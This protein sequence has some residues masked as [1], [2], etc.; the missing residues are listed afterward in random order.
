[1]I[2]VNKLGLKLHPR[3]EYAKDAHERLMAAADAH[4]IKI[5][6]LTGEQEPATV[7][8]CRVVASIGGD[9]TL[10]S[11]VRSAYPSDTPVWGINVGELGFLTTSGVNEIEQ[12]VER[13]AKGDYQVEPRTMIEGTVSWGEHETLLVAL[14]DIVLHRQVPG[15]GLMALDVELN[16][17]FLAA[18]E[19][20][21]LIIST[22]TGSTGY[23]LSAGGSI[24]SPTVAAL[25][26]TPV[27]AH[28]FSAR[29]LVVD[30]SSVLVIRPRLKTEG[31]VAFA[32]ADGQQVAKL[33][34]C[35]VRSG[36]QS[37]DSCRMVVRRSEK[38]AGFV[39]F[40]DVVFSDV[41]R[42]KLG[43]ADAAPSNRLKE[44]PW[45]P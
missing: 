19:A 29:S 13:L 28:S 7:E 44:S 25:E 10:L 17:R 36:K 12:H 15:G 26:I 2:P 41:L 30:D 24:L 35:P 18:Y 43:W 14:N 22:P 4:G 38:T 16:G 42:D 23:T 32:L 3:Y 6:D 27:S 33:V 34:N 20:D 8:D 39:R 5:I 37:A 21:G 9:G 40:E 45:I 31:E 1:M 11:A